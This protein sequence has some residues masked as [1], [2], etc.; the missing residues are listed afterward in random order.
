MSEVL[1]IVLLTG[2]AGACI[3]IGGA[4]ASL[5][6]MSPSWLEREFRHFV[7]AFGGGILLGAVAVVLVPEGISSMDNSLL[8]IPV[9]LVGAFVFFYWRD[10]LG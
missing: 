10:F 7:I 2:L 8:S 9:M 3:P 4:I 6:K 1:T 5:E